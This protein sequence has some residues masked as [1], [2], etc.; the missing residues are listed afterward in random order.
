MLVSFFFAQ[1]WNRTSMLIKVFDL[2]AIGALFADLLNILLLT[3][4][5]KIAGK[6]TNFTKSNV[7]HRFTRRVKS[8]FA[9]PHVSCQF[10]FL[11]SL[12]IQ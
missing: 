1:F 9:C 11:V 3:L 6:L 5:E 4:L 8:K 2:S 10:Y 12:V 7:F